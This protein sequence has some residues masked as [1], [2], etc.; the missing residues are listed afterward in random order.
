VTLD[1]ID[2]LFDQ[3]AAQ[4]P[5]SLA[6]LK[7]KIQTND[8]EPFQIHEALSMVLWRLGGSETKWMIRCSSNRTAPYEY[9][10]RRR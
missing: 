10:R 5:F 6:D 2:K 8:A 9:L 4:S 7:L 3:V 1:E